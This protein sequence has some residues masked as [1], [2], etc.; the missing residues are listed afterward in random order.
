MTCSFREGTVLRRFVV[1]LAALLLVSCGRSNDRE[2]RL[3][4]RAN[5]Q[6]E[7]MATP[8]PPPAFAPVEDVVV[9]AARNPNALFSQQHTLTVTMPHDSVAARFE[10]ARDACLK[11]VSL[12][13]TLTSASLNVNTTVGA[14]I[15]VALPHDKV[16]VYE[17]RLL[18]RLPQDGAGKAEIASRST[19]TQNETQSHADIDRQLAQAIAY[20]DSLEALAKRTTLTV[21]EVIKIH[22]E[23]QQAQ[24][25]VET[26]QA[27]KRASDTKIALET[28]DITLEELTAPP[29][30]TSPF[31]DFWKNAGDGLAASTADMLLRIVNALPWLPLIAIVWIA[32]ARLYRRTRRRAAPTE[33]GG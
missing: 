5:S 12:H 9:T 31:A 28:V 27:S 22:T 17:Q 32:L 16:A 26:A 13:C 18:A 20:R 14:E 4:L 23:L 19:A 10:R 24:E 1:C 3:A 2:M 25:A 7:A 29:V 6:A 11:D 30:P 8:P 21:D 33:R 15:Q